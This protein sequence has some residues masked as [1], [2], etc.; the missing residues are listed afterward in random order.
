[1]KKNIQKIIAIFAFLITA[2]FTSSDASLNPV[3]IFRN[4]P[5]QLDYLRLEKKNEII[6]TLISFVKNGFFKQAFNGSTIID[7][8][9]SL[10]QKEFLNILEYLENDIPSEEGKILV[11]L[12]NKY[13]HLV[14]YQF[15]LNSMEIPNELSITMNTCYDELYSKPSDANRTVYPFRTTLSK[16][17]LNILI[18]MD[19]NNSYREKRELL[20]Y[21]L[22]K[23]K[24]DLLAINSSLKKDNQ[25]NKHY[26]T[27]LI[28]ALQ[29]HSL[30]APIVQPRNIKKIV[31]TTAFI[32][33]AAFIIW[34]LVNKP[35][36]N[37]IST[38]TKNWWNIAWKALE[39][40]L[41]NAVKRV[42]KT[43]TNTFMET[44][45]E[46]LPIVT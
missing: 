17:M 7:P 46:N 11:D 41:D 33:A 12:I 23:T 30:Q 2:G 37:K 34:I 45:R 10:D 13:Y 21:L 40:K 1:M 4:S 43:A 39:E 38:T 6:E 22:G 44:A 27:N 20:V 29:M 9:K 14:L 3:N 24:H 28:E 16:L 18:I 32:F 26:I 42:T 5:S 31:L 36:R 25:V 35:L 8:E 15:I 19:D